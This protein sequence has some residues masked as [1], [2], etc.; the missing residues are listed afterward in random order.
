MNLARLSPNDTSPYRLFLLDRQL[1][2]GISEAGRRIRTGDRRYG[3][4]P[5]TSRALPGHG[6]YTTQEEGRSELCS[7]VDSVPQKVWARAETRLSPLDRAPGSRSVA[8]YAAPTNFSYP[9]SP[10]TLHRDCMASN[11]SFSNSSKGRAPCT[12]RPLI[13]SV[14]TDLIPRD[15]A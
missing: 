10:L 9:S 8:A 7:I 6:A 3:G 5:E 15:S 4:K 1:T 12:T 11:T 13:I 2:I 14:G